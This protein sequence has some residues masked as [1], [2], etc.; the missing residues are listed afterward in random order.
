MAEVKYY[1]VIQVRDVDEAQVYFRYALFLT[2][3]LLDT[4]SQIGS[5]RPVDTQLDADH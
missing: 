5:L 4:T 1:I 2:Y 3:R